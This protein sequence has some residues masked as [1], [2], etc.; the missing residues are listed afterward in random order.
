M[1]ILL[2]DFKGDLIHSSRVQ[3]S[4]DLARVLSG[5]LRVRGSYDLPEISACMAVTQ[6]YVTGN[7]SSFMLQAQR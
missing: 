6:V 7:G 5:Q 1:F 4:T 3:N 2:R